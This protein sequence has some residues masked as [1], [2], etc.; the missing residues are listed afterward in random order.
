[1]ERE[2]LIILAGKH[3]L[4]LVSKQAQRVEIDPEFRTVLAQLQYRLADR[5]VNPIEPPSDLWERIYAAEKTRE[6]GPRDR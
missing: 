5:S 1:M 6:E 4:G 3:A 2:E